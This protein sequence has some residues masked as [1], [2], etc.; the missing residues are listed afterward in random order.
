MEIQL[1]RFWKGRAESH[2]YFVWTGLEWGGHSVKGKSLS[3]ALF[4]PLL[5]PVPSF[6]W[7]WARVG[8]SGEATSAYRSRGAVVVVVVGRAAG[9]GGRARPDRKDDMEQQQ[10]AHPGR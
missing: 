9:L 4:S 7:G 6:S 1:L 2:H 8:V 10:K 5:L 3:R